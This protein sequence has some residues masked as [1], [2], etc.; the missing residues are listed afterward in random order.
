M[1]IS[2]VPSMFMLPNSGVRLFQYYNRGYSDPFF[3]ELAKGSKRVA[4]I[5]IKKQ[6]SWYISKM[7]L[8]KRRTLENPTRLSEADLR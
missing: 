6:N 7:F 5:N 2:A 1:L 4:W 3:A 8:L